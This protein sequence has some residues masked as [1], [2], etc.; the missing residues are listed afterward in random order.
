MDNQNKMASNG[1]AISCETSFEVSANDIN[2]RPVL[3]N[4]PKS[5]PLLVQSVPLLSDK[6]KKKLSLQN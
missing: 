6:L 2:K 5:M 3:V 1:S 4:T